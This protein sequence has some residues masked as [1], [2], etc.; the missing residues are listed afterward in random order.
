MTRIQLRRDTAANWTTDN[1]V[2]AQGEPAV[3]TDTGKRKLGDGTTAW[4]SL[5]YVSGGTSTLAADT[6]VTISSPSDGQVLTY[7]ASATKWENR[8]ASGAAPTLAQLAAAQPFIVDLPENHGAVRNGTTD[9]TAAIKAAISNVVTSG[10]SAGTYYG[11]VWFT[12]GTYAV[13]G[14]PDIT[15][16]G[17]A[18]LPLPLVSSTGQKFVLMLRGVANAS[19]LAHWQQTVPQTAGVTLLTNLNANYDSGLGSAACIGGPTTEQLSTTDGGFSNMLF[20]MDGINVVSN[21]SNPIHVAVDLQCVAQMDIG[22]LGISGNLIPTTVSTVPTAGG[23][24]LRTPQ[25]GNNDNLRVG[26]LSIEGYTEGLIAAE[27]F[28]ADRVAAI[29]CQ[30]AISV[31][32]GSDSMRI[33][34]LST[35]LCQY[36]LSTRN[37]ASGGGKLAQIDIG[38]WDTEEGSAGLA[39]SFHLDD[40]QNFLAGTAQWQSGAPTTNAPPLVNGAAHYKLINRYQG[41]G[42]V[43]SPAVPA[44]TTALV[45]PLW[46]DAAVTVSGGTVTVIAVDGTATGITSGTVIVPSGKTITLTYSAA[47]SWNWVLL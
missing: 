15:H 34:A 44:S 13:F 24:G 21:Y 38:T 18:Q 27:H 20:C 41:P 22:T 7:V 12:A 6:D 43:A 36:H 35:E 1:P 31:R 37:S 39:T 10:I 30:I 23:V 16:T 32:T 45:N 2:L 29:Y 17:R 33:N 25:V 14:A 26:S 9:D 42:H 4:T 5:A 3:E 47:P 8:A 46:R 11:E 40:S 19:A 28:I